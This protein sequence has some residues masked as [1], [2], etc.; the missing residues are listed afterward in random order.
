MQYR[1]GI[2]NSTAAAV[3]LN[4]GF[5]PDKFQ[6][7]NYTKS[8][9]TNGVTSSFWI[10]KVMANANAF[11]TTETS[12]APVQTL[13]TTNG[14][15]PLFGGNFQNTNYVITGITNANPG[16]VTVSSVS[17]TNTMTL[18]NGMTATISGVNG[19]RINPT[20][21][22]IV[23][24]SGTSF[25]MYDLFGNPINTTSLGTYVSGGDLDVFS[26]PPTAPVLDPVTGQVITPGS[27][28][29]LQRDIGYYGITLGTGV[30][31]SNADV[32][33]WE[34]FYS[35]PSGW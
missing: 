6:V 2:I 1:N 20:R 32:L 14:F 31:G 22:V 10:N 23:G 25:N 30:V 33:F 26:Y 18:A 17:P 3:S 28:A 35:T 27:P 4:L 7:T 15:T 19:M 8:A 21:V 24:L 34:A 29:G 9:A 12:G 13:I 16:V 5:V 11:I